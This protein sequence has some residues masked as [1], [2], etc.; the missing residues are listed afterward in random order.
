MLSTGIEALDHRLGGLVAGRYYLVSGVPGSGKTSAALQFLGAGLESGDRCAILT[1]DDPE[2]LIAQGEFLGYDFRTAAEEDRLI[3]LQYRLDFAHNFTRSTHPEIVA[4]ELVDV[5]GDPM[6]SRLVIDSILPFV[7]GGTAVHGPGHALSQVIERISSTVY[8]TIPG[9]ISETYYLPIY[10]RITAAAAGIFHLQT[11]NGRVR[12]FGVRKLRQVATSSDPFRFTIQPGI[13]IVAVQEQTR[14]LADLAPELRRRVVV[15]RLAHAMPSELESSLREAYEVVRYDSLETAFAELSN[16]NFGALLIVLDPRDP[17]GALQLTREMRK[18]G[19]GVPILFL[20]PAHE[21][22]SSTRS[23]ALRA[24]GDDFLTSDI[25]PQEFLEKIEVARQRGHRTP[26]EA[27]RGENLPL[28][29]VGSDGKPLPIEE[30]ELRRAVEHQLTSSSHPFFAVVMLR[31]S[32][33]QVEQTLDVIAAD[34]RVTEGDLICRMSDGRI[35]VYLHDIS[36]R[37][38]RELLARIM[39]AHPELA[40]VHDVEVYSYPVDRSAV[41]EWLARGPVLQEASRS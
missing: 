3:V 28:Q 31:P 25:S 36:R 15:L 29:P 5:L 40:G 20:S 21:L 8:M 22:R 38:V 33:Y 24:G 19:N 16:G 1:Q 11:I 13:G 17:A 9:D 35:G 27:S 30:T 6:P 14:S 4:G 41:Q 10:N 26:A 34:L 39:Q 7:E 18:T 23:R 2:D 12:E 32:P 37:H